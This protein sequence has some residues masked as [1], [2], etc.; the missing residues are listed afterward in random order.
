MPLILAAPLVGYVLLLG[1][2]RSRRGSA[3]VATTTLV[4]M[5]LTTLLVGW[6]RIHQSAPYKTAYQWINITV[7]FTGEQRFQGFGIDLA[8]R[9]DHAVLAAL[10]A[11]L[12]VLIACLAWHRVAGR[13]EQGQVRFHVNVLLFA[14]GAA[15]VLVSGDL[16]ELLA[17]W[18][19]T[20]LGTY[21]LLGH[22]WGTEGAGRRGRVAFAIPFAGDLALLCGVGI[23]YSR[24]GTLTLD[25]VF[26]ALTTTPGVGFKSLTAAAVLIF[27]A[28]AVRASI[29]PFTAWQT[30]TVDAPAASVAAVAGVWPVLAGSLLLRSLPLMGAAGGQAPRIAGFTLGIAAL[31]GPLL[32]LMGAELRRSI[33]LASS[34]AVALTLLGVLYEPSVSIAFTALLAVAAARAGM[35]LAGT[36]AAGAMRTVDMR[37]T[38]G[39]WRRMPATSAALLVGA[40]V[41]PLGGVSAV[42]PRAGGP[43]GIALGAGLALVALSALR[44]YFA[45]AHGPLRRR[46]AFE[47][48][49]VREVPSAVAAAAYVC[50]AAGVVTLGA[51]LFTGW[52]GFLGLG[53]Q[54]VAMG[55]NVLWLIPPMVG[56][57]AAI[58]A[59]GA[60]KDQ[61]LLAGAR[62]GDLAGALWEQVG[63]LYDRLVARPGYQVVR[64]VEDVGLPAAELGVGR[65]FTAAGGLAGSA[66]RSLPWLPTVLALAVVLAAAFALV[67]QGLSR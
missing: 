62:L 7:A 25:N 45:V 15:G 58:V 11:V 20:G 43:A 6:A 54:A 8:F 49:R 40:T 64:G 63:G 17:F 5:L 47:P 42:T 55:T 51:T 36:S 16:A 10:V 19:L 50:L 14:L 18:L 35:L 67:G 31:V 59:F 2:V 24:F 32:G 60:R 46:R 4:V 12:L 61:G 34:G 30:A 57:L 48:E 65:A 28:A 9:V 39:G 27:V 26:S 29:W 13:G 33:L 1:S 22:R 53:G 52:I 21:F 56:V 23:L 44:P 3:N 37:A 38:G 41:L 66:E